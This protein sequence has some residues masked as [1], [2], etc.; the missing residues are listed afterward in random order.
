MKKKFRF[1][2]THFEAFDD[3]TQVP[4]IRAQQATEVLAGPAS[5]KRT[6]MLGDFNSNVPGVQPGDEQA[7][8]AI[9][10]AGFE[11]AGDVEPAELL[12]QQPVQRRRR[13][14][15]TTRSTTS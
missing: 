10:D 4:S 15:S 11:R 12:R 13:R 6:I 2:N 3:E 7:F 14:S 5:A 8:Q 1:V 9:L